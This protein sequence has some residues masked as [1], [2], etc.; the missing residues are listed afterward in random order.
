MSDHYR[1]NVYR[2]ALVV[3]VTLEKGDC[4][5]YSFATAAGA[6]LVDSWAAVAAV[7]KARRWRRVKA[8]RALCRDLSCLH[9]PQLQPQAC[10]ASL[11][12]STSQ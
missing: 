7:K 5:A 1:T 10:T 6:V 9:A 3:N 8:P 11:R 4:S 12:R 2:F